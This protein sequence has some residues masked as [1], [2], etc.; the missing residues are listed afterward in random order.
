M[1]IIKFRFWDKQFNKFLYQLSEEHYLDLKRFDIQQFTGLLD[2]NGK[3]VY[4]G[5]IVRYSIPKSDGDY[6]GV[7]EI[8]WNEAYCGFRIKDILKM[9][10]PQTPFIEVIGNIYENSNLLP[11]TKVKGETI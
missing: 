6:K 11:P 7:G 9:P 2:K 8:F 1:R 5:D 3:E 4:E 10:Q